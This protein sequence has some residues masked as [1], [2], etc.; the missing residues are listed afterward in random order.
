MVLYHVWTNKAPTPGERT[1]R[2]RMSAEAPLGCDAGRVY[3][4]FCATGNYDENE[5]GFDLLGLATS[6]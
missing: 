4:N 3:W 6:T 1:D 5:S 2:T